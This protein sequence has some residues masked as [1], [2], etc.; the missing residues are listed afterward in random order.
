[1]SLTEH[2]KFRFDKSSRHHAVL[3]GL[4]ASALV[5]GFLSANSNVDTAS[6]ERV[7]SSTPAH[8]LTLESQDPNA[9]VITFNSPDGV[10]VTGKVRISATAHSKDVIMAE[11][12]RFILNGTDI[13]ENNG[14][15]AGNAGCAGSAGEDGKLPSTT[16]GREVDVST[17]HQGNN[18][19]KITATDKNG[20]TGSL[21]TS[22][23]R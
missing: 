23:V 9:P 6:T 8:S 22:I 12:F 18:P 11:N 17:L 1:M 15:L 20:H 13:P 16:C 3:G 21:S 19:L 7:L 2:P 4:A 5:S 14:G 10:P